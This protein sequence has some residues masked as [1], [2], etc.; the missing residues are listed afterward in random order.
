MKNTNLT[1]FILKFHKSYITFELVRLILCTHTHYC[2]CLHVVLKSLSHHITAVR[3]LRTASIVDVFSS[4]AGNSLDG[5]QI[6]CI[7]TARVSSCKCYQC[8]N[9][10][11][12]A[13]FK[14]NGLRGSKSRHDVISAATTLKCHM[15]FV[16]FL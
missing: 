13:E 8:Q 6:A 14:R 12:Y 16:I 5:L 1:V 15:L 4:I 9:Q 10:T 3:K 2:Y 7:R 11:S